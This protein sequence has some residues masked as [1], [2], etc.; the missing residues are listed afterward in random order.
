V[1]HL[2]VSVN[3]NFCATPRVSVYKS[4]CCTD[5]CPTT[6]PF[7]LHLNVSVFK[8][9]GLVSVCLQELCAT[10][11]RVCLQNPS[12]RTT[13]YLGLFRNM[14]VCC[15][16]LVTLSKHRNKLKKNKK[17]P[18]FLV[19]RNKPKINQNRLSF[20][21][22]RFKPKIFLFVLRTPY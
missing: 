14:Y 9:A 11:G 7:V 8:S 10:P 3:K 5:V 6:R 12:P 20:G 16:C 13:W 22:F 19:S 2:D 15:G 1:L 4:L 18:E 21:S 17:K